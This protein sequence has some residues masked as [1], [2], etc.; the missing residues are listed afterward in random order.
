MAV[1]SACAAVVFAS[2]GTDS[3]STWPLV[4][5]PMSSVS[6]NRPWPTTFDSKPLSTKAMRLWA[7]SSWSLLI[8]LVGGTALP[9][10]PVVLVSRT[11]YG[12]RRVVA[13]GRTP[14]GHRQLV[15]ATSWS[16]TPYRVA[17]SSVTIR[18]WRAEVAGTTMVSIPPSLSRTVSTVR[19]AFPSKLVW[20]R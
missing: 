1:A 5:K 3:S 4:S 6:R 10:A 2:P 18:T 16:E 8:L 20:T 17:R 12:V 14:R 9:F 11:L 13:L 19:Q 7:R 15:T